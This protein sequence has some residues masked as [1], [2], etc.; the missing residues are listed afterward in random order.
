MK[1]SIIVP[2]FNEEKRISTCLRSIRSA[3][4]ANARMDLETETIVADNN[5]T[6]STAELARREGA[7]VVFEPVN[8]ISR[9]RNAGARHATGDWFLFVDADCEL[10]A[11]SVQDMLQRIDEG[12]CAGGGSIL[13][14]DAAPWPG[15]LTIALWNRVSLLFTLVAG[16]FIFCRADAFRDIGGFSLDLFA[17]EEVK[18]GAELKRWARAR[19]LQVVILRKTRHVTSGR[20]FGLFTKRE[21]A[22]IL[23][24]SVTA[25][26]QA[27]RER[28]DLHYDG[29]R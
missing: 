19:D 2:A 25:P 5:S 13:T 18:F 17:A 15:R 26:R 20:K 1:L 29:R 24:R 22:K 6:D 9:A 4:V 8:Q 3:L 7:G 16:C 14:L 27:V 23:W 11:A 21:W 10:S 28:Q 12:T